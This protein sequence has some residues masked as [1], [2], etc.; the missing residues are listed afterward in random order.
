MKKK[1][2]LTIPIMLLSIVSTF[3]LNAYAQNNAV[4]INMN[5]QR[6]IGGVSELDRN[7]YFSVH[8]TGNDAEQAAFRKNYNVTGGRGFWGPSGYSNA[9]LKNPIGTYPGPRVGN[10]NPRKVLFNEVLTEHPGNAF[11]DKM[12]VNKAGDWAVEY[13][14]NY[15]NDSG[16]PEYYEPMNEPFVH[17]KDFYTG[18]WNADNEKRIRE[19]MA[20]LYNAIGQKIKASPA[21]VN[22][23]VIGYSA[24]W[25]EMELGDFGHWKDNQKMFM[26]KAGDNMYAF[27]THLYDGINVTGQDTKRSGSNSEAILDLIEAYSFIKWN[28]IKPHA[29]TEYGAIEKGYGTNY[30]D[31]ASVQTV[32]SINHILFNLLERQDHLAQSTPFITGKATWHITAANN[33]QPYGAVLWKPSNIGQP[34]PTAWVY[35]PRIYFYE[36]WKEVKGNRISI[37]CEN[38]DIQTQAFVDGKK[39]YVAFSNLH[40]ADQTINLNM[41]AGTNGL[42]NVKIKDLKIYEQLD[43]VYLETTV[44][45]AP[46]SLKL[47]SSQSVVLEYTFTNDITFNNALRETKY[48]T[49]NYLTPI[50]AN[51][52]LNFNFNNVTQG[53]GFANIRMSIGRKH[54]VSKSPI[55]KINGTVVTVPTNWAGYDQANRTDFF[56]MINIPFSTNLLKKDNVITLEFPDSGGT[57]SSMILSVENYDNPATTLGIQTFGAS[58]TG[59]KNGE[60]ALTPFKSNTYK[61]A[62]TGKDVNATYDF[63]SAYKIKNLASGSYNLVITTPSDAKF[64][65]EYKIA[66]EEPKSITVT[67]KF[68]AEAQK[69]NLELEGSQNYTINHDGLTFTTSKSAIALSLDNGLNAIEVKGDKDCQ[70][71]YSEKIMIDSESIAHPNP[72]TDKLTINTDSD[73]V[74]LVTVF[75][76]EGKQLYFKSHLPVNNKIELN[77][78]T[79]DKGIYFMVLDSKTKNQK[80]KLIKK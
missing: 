34:N 64:K 27:S 43:P 38:P 52:S 23:K 12:D 4:Q 11:L 14:K 51:T 72:F 42:V 60:I 21:L 15:S 66:I 1:Y 59:S 68:D 29:I 62:I 22:M 5:C 50:V 24:A 13:F 78:S 79:I 17:A 35:T 7:K 2:D 54:N 8:D 75:T 40:H 46:T 76:A 67:S 49:N 30:S 25:P 61:V 74:V 9:Q 6:Y 48:Y 41:I 31:V 36:L 26:D 73:S 19:Q 55:V 65:E 37:K 39:M 45:Q 32:K 69:V 80:I 16:R 56:G 47:I 58:C 33:Y 63:S 53:F 28:T 10:D 70:G 44:T 77:L 20:L 3:G 18:G 57:V 71:I